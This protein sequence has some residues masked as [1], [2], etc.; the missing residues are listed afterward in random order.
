MVELGHSGRHALVEVEEL[1]AGRGA[2]GEGV[3]VVRVG[4]CTMTT[5]FTVSLHL[6]FFITMKLMVEGES[7]IIGICIRVY[8]KHR[9]P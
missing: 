5:W 7:S 9:I 1:G 6:L 8:M 3:G 4:L 2:G